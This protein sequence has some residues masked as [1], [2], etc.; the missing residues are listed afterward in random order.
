MRRTGTALSSATGSSG[1]AGS[2]PQRVFQS[3]W[4]RLWATSSSDWLWVTSIDRAARAWRRARAICL[5]VWVAVMASI[6]V[7]GRAFAISACIADLARRLA[8]GI[9]GMDVL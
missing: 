2:A 6:L 4:P 5:A 9:E 8:G 3:A 7:A 1:A